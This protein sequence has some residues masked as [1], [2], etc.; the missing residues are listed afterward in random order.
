[1][2]PIKEKEKPEIEIVKSEEQEK[3]V[4]VNQPESAEK[5][6]TELEDLR[7]T[8]EIKKLHKRLEYSNRQTE[9][10][11]K[12]MEEMA[13][14]IQ[15]LQPP[16]QNTAEGQDEL[17]KLAEKDWKAAVRAL[18]RD[19]ALKTFQE[20]QNGM[21]QQQARNESLNE[22]EKSKDSVRKKYPMIDDE[23]SREAQVY[24]E[25]LNEN[26]QLLKNV[27]GPEL[28]M[29]KMEEKLRSSRNP[30]LQRESRVRAA[31][32]PPG[33]TP[34]PGGPIILT[35]EEKELCDRTGTPYDRY[36]SMRKMGAQD[37]RE[38]VVAE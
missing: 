8:E 28:A 38:G 11:L 16:T 7:Q 10:A 4:I 34:N 32:I 14:R 31:Y 37:F 29:Y 22:N 36:A 1:M 24:I 6:E 25:V 18:G 27:Y 2:P 20:L 5:Q 13:Q 15:S 33:R 26:P 17:D 3:E 35:E 21:A 12:K 19:E 23:N 30:E 9:K